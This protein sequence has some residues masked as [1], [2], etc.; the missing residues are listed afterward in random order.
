MDIF[1]FTAPAYFFAWIAEN[2]ESKNRVKAVE[3]I[4]KVLVDSM[5]KIEN[6]STSS[7]IF[8]SSFYKK[9]K[10]RGRFEDMVD[11]FREPL[12]IGVPIITVRDYF[13]Y[14]S[15]IGNMHMD[16]SGYFLGLMDEKMEELDPKV[17][18]AITQIGNNFGYPHGLH[19][20]AWYY[21]YHAIY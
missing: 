3:Q 13:D 17:S 14:I 2:F 8:Y 5:L 20:S 18:V 11:F 7:T 10:E 15:G 1:E 19:F 16:V 21:F 9:C 12:T 6:D 4:F